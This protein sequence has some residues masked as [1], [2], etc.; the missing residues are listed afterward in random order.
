[1]Q[2][3][4]IMCKQCQWNFCWE[5]TLIHTYAVLNHN[6]QSMPVGFLLGRYF[7]SL[8]PKCLKQTD[9]FF[10]AWDR[11]A[12]DKTMPIVISSLCGSAKYC[13]GK[14]TFS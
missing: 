7:D 6:V 12:C 10:K 8:I 1:M 9:F 14:S 5:G 13:L 2:S 11:H 4:S 3:L